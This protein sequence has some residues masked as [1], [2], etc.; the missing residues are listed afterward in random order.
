MGFVQLSLKVQDEK[1]QSRS[2]LW[3]VRT[4]KMTESADEDPVIQP[5]ARVEIVLSNAVYEAEL[6]FDVSGSFRT[7]SR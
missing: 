5:K 4:L 6:N 3:E 2:K 7:C 1:P